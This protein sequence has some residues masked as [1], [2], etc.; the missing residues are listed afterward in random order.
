MECLGCNTIVMCA[1]GHGN[2]QVGSVVPSFSARSMLP[3]DAGLRG[4]DIRKPGPGEDRHPTSPKGSMKGS[5]KGSTEGSARGSTKGSPKGSTYAE[6]YAESYMGSHAPSYAGSG[7]IPISMSSIS[8]GSSISQQSAHTHRSQQSEYYS[9]SERSMAS[10]APRTEA[11]Y[12]G[13]EQSTGSSRARTAASYAASIAKS[14]YQSEPSVPVSVVSSGRVSSLGSRGSHGSHGSRYSHM[15]RSEAPSH[16]SGSQGSQQSRAP[17]DNT[18][19]SNRET[20]RTHLPFDEN[21]YH[22]GS[23]VSEAPSGIRAG[24]SSRIGGRPRY[25]VTPIPSHITGS[26]FYEPSDAGMSGRDSRSN[27]SGSS[28]GRQTAIKVSGK[29]GGYDDRTKITTT[30]RTDTKKESTQSKDDAMRKAIE[31]ERKALSID[32]MKRKALENQRKVNTQES[33]STKDTM[34]TRKTMKTSDTSIKRRR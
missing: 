20:S 2:G 13:S 22:T 17:T 26:K 10:G 5:T 24:T 19:R 25:E 9:A 31:N 29:S 32:E 11:S 34:E 1:T 16:Y 33:R 4:G 6:P 7:G 12:V 18:I 3:D 28:K 15:S 30:T 23:V 14:E 21:G 27:Q 8:P